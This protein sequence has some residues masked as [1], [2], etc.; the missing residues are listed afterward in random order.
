VIDRE[1]PEVIE[2]DNIWELPATHNVKNL[3]IWFLNNANCLKSVYHALIIFKLSSVDRSDLP[4]D[5]LPPLSSTWY[6]E[7]NDTPSVP[8]CLLKLSQISRA[9]PNRL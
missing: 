1:G 8:F 2:G 3:F 9:R 5:S 6:F 4:F 7:S